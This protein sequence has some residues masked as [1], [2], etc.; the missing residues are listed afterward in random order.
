MSDF[1]QTSEMQLGPARVPVMIE[2]GL[3]QQLAEYLRER[4]VERYDDA[5]DELIRVGIEALDDR[6]DARAP[7]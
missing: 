5:L 4:G 2:K 7:R 3:A 1:V 6:R